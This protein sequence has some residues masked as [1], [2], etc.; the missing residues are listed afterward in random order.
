MKKPARTRSTAPKRR[1]ETGV[2]ILEAR[3]APAFTATVAGSVASFLG[4]AASDSLDIT[5]SN[6]FLVHN[7]FTAGDAGFNSAMDFDTTQAGDQKLTVD[8]ASIIDVNGG[9]G[10]DSVT[11]T[12]STDFDAGTIAIGGSISLTT[13]AGVIHHAGARLTGSSLSIMATTGIGSSATPLATTVSNFEA[14]TNTGGI[15]VANFNRTMTLGSASALLTGVNAAG[16]D[17][18][19]TNNT[20]NGTNSSITIN[21]AV[22]NSAGGNITIGTLNATGDTGNITV[23]AVVTASGGNGNISITAE[24]NMGVTAAISALGTGNI[25]LIS[26]QTV[27]VSANAGNFSNSGAGT[28]S[29][30]DGN[31]RIQSADSVSL[32]AAVLASGT[33]TITIDTNAAI[34][35]VGDFTSTATGTLSTNGG[36]ITL[37]NT[38][39]T[40]TFGGA[41]TITGGVGSLQAGARVSININ[42][43]ISITGAGIISMTA[44]S[45]LNGSGTFTSSGAGTL[46]VTGGGAIA[47]SGANVTLGAAA[48][49]T[50]GNGNLSVIAVNNIAINA[51]L[52]TAGLGGNGAGIAMLSAGGS[53]TVGIDGEIVTENGTVSTNSQSLTNGGEVKTNGAGNINLFANNSGTLFTNQGSIFSNG[54]NIQTRFDDYDLQA[55]SS[56]TVAAHR[57]VE[58]RV[59][60]GGVGIDLGSAAV[61]ANFTQSEIDTITAGQLRLTSAAN[62]TLSQSIVLNNAKVPTLVLQAVGGIVDGTA[63]EQTDLTVTNLGIKVSTGI[64]DADDLD[65][66]VT[67]LGFRNVTSGAVNISNS[68]DLTIGS[69]FDVTSSTNLAP[70]AS[71]TLA[72]SGLLNLAVGVTTSGPLTLQSD[73]AATEAAG[74]VITAPTLRLLGAGPFTLTNPLNNINSLSADTTGPITYTDVDSFNAAGVSSGGADIHLTALSGVITTPPVDEVQTLS[75]GGASGTFTLTFNGETTGSLDI[76]SPTLASDIQTELNNLPGVSGSGGAIFVNQN[77]SVFDLRFNGTYAGLDVSQ[78]TSTPQPG[79]T[80]DVATETDGGAIHSYGGSITL[81]TDAIGITGL[82]DAGSGSVTIT[83]TTLNTNIDLGGP[84]LPSV[85]GNPGTLGLTQTELDFVTADILRVGDTFS[86]NNITLTTPIVSPTDTLSLLGGFNG[87]IS[88]TPG[89]SLTTTNLLLAGGGGV[90]LTDPANNVGT[91]AGASINFF[92]FVNSTSFTVGAVDPVGTALFDTFGFFDAGVLSAGPI[93]LTALG[94][95]S[96]ITVNK[97]VSSVVFSDFGSPVTI[98][99]DNIDLNAGVEASTFGIATLQPL[100]AGRAINLGT[101]VAGKFSLTDVELNLISA[102]TLRV[103]NDAAGDITTTVGVTPLQAPVFSLY[104]AGSIT[105][106]VGA[107]IG[108]LDGLALHAGTGIGTAPNPLATETPNL[109]FENENGLV[110]IS[111]NG[112]LTINEVDD[113]PTSANHGTTTTLTARATGLPSPGGI[114]FAVDTLSHG[115]LNATA[116]ESPLPQDDIR[117]KF[118][119]NVTSEVGDIRFFAGDGIIA[120]ENSVISALNDIYM[121]FGDNDQDGISFV[122]LRGFIFG[123]LLTLQAGPGHE[124]ITLANLDNIDVQVI[125]IRTGADTTPDSVKLLDSALSHEINASLRLGGYI[126]VLGFKSEVRIFETTAVDTL[127]IGGREGNDTITAQP[128]IESKVGIILDG[129]AGDDVLTGNG[130]LV[131][132]DG[133]DTLN[134]GT[135]N[136]VLIGDGGVEFLYGL[137]TNN[138]LVRYAAE[139]PD[140]LIEMK[141]ITGVTAGETLIGL[142]A[143]ASTG[144]LYAIGKTAAGAGSLY[145]I[146]PLTG[147]ATLV[148]ALT[149]STGDVF[150]ILDGNEFGFDFNPAADRLRVVSDSGQS[151]RINP[152]TGAVTTDATL[153]GPALGLIGAAYTNNFGGTP[154]TTLFGIDSGTDHLFMQGGVN[155]SPSPNGGVLT[156]I[157]ALGLDVDAVLGFDIVPGTGTA[158]AALVVGGVS[159]LY[160]IDLYNG[161]ATFVGNFDGGGTPVTLRGLAVGTTQGNDILNGGAGNNT[162]S[163][164]EGSDILLGGIGNDRLFGGNGADII[165]GGLG[166]DTLDGGAGFD[167]LRETR[168]AD[169]TLT[170]SALT[171]GADMPET[172]T[173]FE[174]IELTGGASANTFHVG[175]FTGR[176]RVTGSEGSDTLDYGTSTLGIT[177]DLDLVGA[178]QILNT[179]GASLV[180]GD[181]AENFIGSAFNDTISVDALSFPRLID[182]AAPSTFPGTVTAPIPPGD[183][184][185]VDGRGQFVKI[186]KSGSSGTVTTPGF[187]DVTFTDIET[188]DTI[189]SSGDGGFGGTTGTSNALSTSVNY[190]AGGKPKQVVTGDLNGDGFD[191]IVTINPK[192]KTLSVLLAAGDGTFLPTVNYKLKGISPS[193]VVLGNVDGKLD[194]SSTD[195]D[196]DVI[197]TSATGAKIA[198]LLNDGTGAFGLPATFK[199]IGGSTAKVKV[200]D[201]N[202]DG[203]ID[204]ATLNTSRGALN[205]LLNTGT[206]VAG[207]A[208]FGPAKRVAVGRTTDFGIAN[209]D[210]DLLSHADIVVAQATGM[211][212]VLVGAGDGNFAMSP[213][214]YSVGSNPS[215]IA[216]ADFN[217]DGLIDV[218]VNHVTSEHFVSILF[219]RGATGGDLFQ[220]QIRTT[221]AINFRGARTMIAGDFNGDGDADLAFGSDDNSFLRI[222]RGSGDGSFQRTVTFLTNSPL[223]G[224]PLATGLAVGDFNGDGAL[225]FVKSNAASNFISVV[226]RTPTV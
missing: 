106:N 211:L 151:L 102:G 125:N 199:T 7:R 182:G 92:T 207:T 49:S 159:G 84:D 191:D 206:G 10:T 28:V 65:I 82:V 40:A 169:F 96:K 183:H 90:L 216:L 61:G 197:I 149:A 221:F 170:N 16:G 121:Q 138:E 2:E 201:F 101:K 140:T 64:G 144:V 196:L 107:V 93:S 6:G 45:D 111:N 218:A 133:N 48:T 120:E 68:G 75:I 89:S 17:I 190:L 74:G 71:T 116:V 217:N 126:S 146:D 205:I 166:L 212:R 203:L 51:L 31:I 47:L 72:S 44:D 110:N 208:S 220:P 83:P 69:V 209:F 161:V 33:G 154:N 224:K 152:D 198:V 42:A 38:T 23:N 99:A 186:Q 27:G 63:G 128:G 73:G 8:A 187:S 86:P 141:A 103:G 36:N 214:K 98:T 142:D 194:G 164:G 222:A 210:G 62:I 185:T 108:A 105:T 175:A 114:I 85:L 39:N 153:S 18:M 81:T 129:G 88:Q 134:G 145:T 192:S 180:L 22:L 155:G 26:D 13:S 162:L 11:E 25:T 213:T 127:T 55:G 87:V 5:E 195:T 19:I 132:G 219:G 20:N 115:T 30:V 167:T 14:S 80:A 223:G 117:V 176:L 168:D 226:L 165:T 34:D 137:T 21:E 60:T 135:G 1:R 54:G 147:T 122:D 29:V 104:T 67:K 35:G 41:T 56:M 177:V 53:I 139:A 171:I 4:D 160:T 95:N 174:S 97:H 136:D 43:P 158:Y 77:G 200:G 173:G 225:D 46:S 52:S 202:N 37:T 76:L 91:I 24:D 215:G 124:S 78:I 172:L 100:T 181:V 119:I 156:D 66:A 109:A 204:I 113:L 178:T 57:E 184:L 32:G 189:N 112:T 143:R 131:G 9:G 58:L 130:I 50:G 193:D 148:A 79:V 118:L 123:R 3:I 94:A 15:F 163:G 59:A 12:R 188:V 179:G 150:T 70:G 157:G